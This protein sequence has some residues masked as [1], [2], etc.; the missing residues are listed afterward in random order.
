MYET[1]V[2]FIFNSTEYLKDFVNLYGTWVYLLVFVIIFSETGLV[3]FPWLPGDGFIL[4]VGVVAES[5]ELNIW[6]AMFLM[7]IAAFLGN[8]VN[9]HIG[10]YF[11]IR[12]VQ[13]DKVKIV[14]QKHLDQTH[15]FFE[16]HGQKAVILSR[17]V[18]VFR[19]FVPFVAGISKMDRARF[20]NYTFW[21]GVAWVLLFGLLGFYFG[22]LPW[23][24]QNLSFI[25]IFLVVV[26]IIPTLVAA[27]RA[28][29]R[30]A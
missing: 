27:W 19:T 25:Y 30:N 1:F 10:K 9:Y 26:T 6:L 4:A 13:S 12:I 21:G 23:V 20:L 8:A 2:D 15:E 16:K 3:I 22:K 28:R 14:K 7:S 17:F 11:G 24:Q 18:P 29:T 5:T